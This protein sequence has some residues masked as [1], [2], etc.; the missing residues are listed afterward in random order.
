MKQTVFR[1]Q[2]GTIHFYDDRFFE[3]IEGDKEQIQGK[4]YRSVLTRY[5]NQDVARYFSLLLSKKK[6]AGY[7]RV[8]INTTDGR[9]IPLSIFGY[10]VETDEGWSIIGIIIETEQLNQELFH[11]LDELSLI[12]QALNNSVILVITD[13]TGRIT[14]ANKHLC[15]ISGYDEHELI[16]RTHKMVNSGYHSTRFFQE[17]WETILSG[18]T[19]HG[20]IKNRK[21]DGSFYWTDAT[22]VPML[23]E[24]GDIFQYMAI[25]YDI[26][27]QKNNEE[28]IRQLANSD[29]LTGVP[30]RRM[31]DQQLTKS[32]AWARK[33]NQHFG[34]LFIDLDS[35]KY[36]ND[37]KGHTIG[38]ELLVKVSQRLVE[39][40]GDS[41]MV[42]RVGGDEFAIIIY[43]TESI[44]SLKATAEELLQQFKAPF[45]IQCLSI[46][47]TCSV[48][49]AIFPES[50][51]TKD[52][53][54]KNA[55]AAMYEVKKTRKN[56]YLF[57]T[58]LLDRS[59]QRLFQ[60][61]NDLREAS[62]DEQF[63]LVYQPKVCP[64]NDRVTGLEALVRWQ[65]PTLG[66]ISPSEFIPIAEEIGMLNE[67]NEWVLHQV[68]QQI[69]VWVK[70]GY[71]PIPISVNLS[72]CQFVQS[73]FAEKFLATI[74]QFDLKTSWIQIEITESILM[75][76]ETQVQVA[77]NIFK[78]NGIKVALDDFGTGYSSLS[79]LLKLDLDIL[80]IDKSLIQGISQNFKEQKLVRT[81]I[82]LGKD[83]GLHVVAE[84]VETQAEFDSLV[85]N[86]VDEIQGYYYSRPL[87]VLETEKLLLER[88]IP[89]N[90][91]R[92][93]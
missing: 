22:I 21:K 7:K 37:T 71:T 40:V 25:R 54:M 87:T 75:A 32:I 26:T 66:C 76:N 17:L 31:F 15:E 82:Q 53:M 67:L 55:D 83:L 49:V 29:S 2:K 41:G 23:N 12:H 69:E 58:H 59:D 72:A 56:D 28:K 62:Y 64:K 78:K 93:E 36:I 84:G 86:N 45:M 47:M 89:K 91:E 14:Y 77:L 60:I 50:G 30:N 92:K 5:I 38:D 1:I 8:F 44:A 61:Q 79:Y 3:L 65:H 13:A 6:R 73:C 90:Q 80:K 11:T 16:G 52:D 39:I 33:H 34:V 81:V 43:E 51:E 4:N 42:A 85:I 48:G 74:A 46:W 70:Q 27:K 88:I 57:S 10:G 35:F 68:C 18:K 24:H 63:Y 19:W 9:T 20:E